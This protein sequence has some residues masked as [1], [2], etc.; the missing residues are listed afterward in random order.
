MASASNQPIFS[1]RTFR[2]E[3]KADWLQLEELLHRAEAGSTRSLSDEELLE[4]PVLYRAALSSLSVARETSL[5]MALVSYLEGLCTRAYFF[6]YGV[7]TG[8]GERIAGFF[9]DEWPAAIRSIWRETLLSVALMLAGTLAAYLL[10]SADPDWYNAI[11]PGGL[12]GERNPASSTE[13]LRATLYGGGEQGGLSV[14]ATALFTHNSQVSIF[15]FALGFAFGVP[16]ALLMM[17]NGAI[18]GAFVALFV[19]HDLGF[20]LGGWLLIH[21]STELFAIALAGAA[22]LHIGTRIIFP[23]METRLNAARKAGRT[24]ATAMIGV[25]IMLLF[26]G[27][28]EGFGRQL[29]TDD[30]TRYA[31][32]A[33]MFT[34]WCAYFYTPG[35][36]RGQR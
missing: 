31:I 27:I 12:A 33:A 16:T 4:L 35:L 3:R 6:V 11:V 13:A 23:G 30:W 20:E 18:L 19:S 9:T 1:S 14:F 24:A 25:I 5:D 22:G 34:G 2:E 26:A 29:I 21:G 36:I 8:F 28:L 32:A 10:V 17:Y 15:A 7:R